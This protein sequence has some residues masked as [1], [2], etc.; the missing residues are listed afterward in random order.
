[1]I[2]KVESVHAGSRHH[3]WGANFAELLASKKIDLLRELLPR[4]SRLAFLVSVT[5]PLDVPQLRETKAH[6]TLSS[7]G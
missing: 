3:D 6:E 4:L 7:Y 2:E 1:M 5:N